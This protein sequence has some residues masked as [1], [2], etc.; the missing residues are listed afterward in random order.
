MI[1]IKHRIKNLEDILEKKDRVSLAWIMLKASGQEAIDF[2]KYRKINNAYL[3]D[4]QMRAL[5]NGVHPSEI[6]LT[7][8]QKVASTKK[9]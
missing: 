1:S 5:R 9:F 6:E 4:S 3:N 7:D 8:D 2:I